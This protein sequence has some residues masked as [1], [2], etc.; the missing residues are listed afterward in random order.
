MALKAHTSTHKALKAHKAH[1]PPQTFPAHTQMPWQGR[2]AFS[3]FCAFLGGLS[4]A[5]YAV[6]PLNAPANPV[7][8]GAA[9][10]SPPEALFCWGRSPRLI[11]W[12]RR[13]RRTT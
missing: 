1:I 3:A 7:R 2:E 4:G 6:L 9:I 12:L 11:G 10:F 5:P 8:Q 13:S